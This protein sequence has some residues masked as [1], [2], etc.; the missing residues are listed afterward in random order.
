MQ[1]I[2]V[3]GHETGEPGYYFGIGFHFVAWSGPV[4]HGMGI[5][6]KEKKSLL[7]GVSLC[8]MGGCIPMVYRFDVLFHR[9]ETEREFDVKETTARIHDTSTIILD[10]CG[11]N[12]AFY[13]AT[14]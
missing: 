14:Y 4:C 12:D 2:V 13:V 10:R 8:G 6:G 9:G 3:F 11:G 5:K 1:W 7:A